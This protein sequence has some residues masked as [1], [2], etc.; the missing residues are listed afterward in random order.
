MDTTW[1]ALDEQGFIGVFET[2]EDGALPVHAAAGPEGGRYDSWPIDAL[3]L[4]RMILDGEE[5]AW[6]D[7]AKPTV[8]LH[9]VVILVEDAPRVLWDEDFFVVHEA[10]PRMLATRR[11]LSP[12]RLERLRADAHV[13]RVVGSDAVYELDWDAEGPLFRFVNDDY[14][15]PGNYQRAHGPQAPINASALPFAMRDQLAGVTLPLRFAERDSVHL[16]DHMA[17][18]DCETWGETTL[19]GEPLAPGP[20]AQRST[21]SGGATI[22]LAVSAL[23]AALLGLIWLLSPG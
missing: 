22:L 5:L 18:E 20:R 19:R 23:I 17:D 1:Y 8:A 15:D 6:S 10:G 7:D 4:A 11:K 14:G 9:L 3:V 21:D 2:G 16:A 13:A 12:R